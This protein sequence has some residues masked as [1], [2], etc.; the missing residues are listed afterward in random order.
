M[1]HQIV[2]CGNIPHLNQVLAYQISNEDFRLLC[3]ALDVKTVREVAAERA[4]VCP[5]MLRCIERLVAIDQLLNNARDGKWQFVKQFL[6]QQADIVNEKPP[7]RKYYLAHFLASTGQLD[8]FKDLSNLSEFKLD[9]I[10]DNKTINQVAR[11]NNHI[12][13]AEY[14]E[15]LCP[16]INQIA[17]NHNQTVVASANVSNSAIQ[18]P[19]FSHGF[20]DDPGIMIFSLNP[21]SFG[22][23]FLSPTDSLSS[24]SHHHHHPL[25]HG[26][27]F[28][29][30]SVF[31][32]QHSTNSHQNNQG[33]NKTSKVNLPPSMTDEQQADYEKTVME[34]IKKFSAD[35]LQ[36]AITCC[37]TKGILRD[38]GKTI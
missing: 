13:F 18:S 17:E 20:H 6:R 2:F 26:H 33:N 21:N 3:K 7:Y 36:N 11:E 4:H 16:N 9:L 37:I 19:S 12:E 28:A 38:P 29:T 15:N 32:G 25:S 10:A 23:M 8:M 24:S 34:N 31:Q 22:S 14:I 5:Q 30:H 27:S 35:N 1:L